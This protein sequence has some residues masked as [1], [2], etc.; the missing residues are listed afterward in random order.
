MNTK[1][2]I[3]VKSF[4][5]PKNSIESSHTSVFNQDQ[6]Q[7]NDSTNQL[8]S[9]PQLR[10]PKKR[11]LYTVLRSPHIDKKSREQ[12]EM[13]WHKQRFVLHTSK[14]KV[15]KQLLNLKLHSVPGIQVKVVFNYQS[16]LREALSFG[17]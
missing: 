17:A 15:H 8:L 14:R 7:S 3:I 11:T 10:L 5:L 4:D 2:S 1:I 13:R 6:A 12:F 9:I 16:R